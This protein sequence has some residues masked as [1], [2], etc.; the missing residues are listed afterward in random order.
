MNEPLFW[1]PL[2]DAATWLSNRTGRE[3]DARRLIDIVM[4]SGEFGDPKPTVIKAASPPDRKWARF[5]L[6]GTAAHRESVARPLGPGMGDVPSS[7]IFLR[8]EYLDTI[9]LCTN[10]LAMILLHGYV[11]LALDP[12]SKGTVWIIPFGEPHRATQETCGINRADLQDLA[13]GLVPTPAE[14]GA[15]TGKETAQDAGWIATAR[16]YADAIWRA[17]NTN[18]NPNVAEI[19]R[20]VAKQFKEESVVGPRGPLTATTIERQALRGWKKPAR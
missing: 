11:D 12:K 10:D 19:A 9:G 5:A 7:L 18:T 6:P 16:E 14:T 4:S 20:R 1:N 15:T 13:A 3:I 2:S 8:W 17:R